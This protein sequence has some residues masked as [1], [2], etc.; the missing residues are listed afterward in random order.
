MK[1]ICLDKFKHLSISDRSKR[2]HQVKHE[3]VSSSAY[4]PGMKQ[5]DRWIIAGSNDLSSHLA[6]QDRVGVVED[7]IH[8]MRSIVVF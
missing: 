1:G 6:F 7:G 2:F 4:L 3:V 8:R 5:P